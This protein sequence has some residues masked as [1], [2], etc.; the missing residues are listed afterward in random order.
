MTTAVHNPD[1]YMYEFQHFLTHSKKKIGILLGAGAPNSINTS[2][3]GGDWNPLIPD[4]AGL[5]EIVKASLNEATDLSAFE[6]IAESLSDDFISINGQSY[7]ADSAIIAKF[8]EINKRRIAKGDSISLKVLS[9]ALKS[10][11]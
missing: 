8:R 6:A 7:S 5:T 3:E 10:N 11:S 2:K 9:R 4:I 1:Q